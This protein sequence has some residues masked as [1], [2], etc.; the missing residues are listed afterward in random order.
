L[1]LLKGKPSTGDVILD[2]NNR[3]LVV[4]REQQALLEFVKRA[5]RGMYLHLPL[6]LVMGGCVELFAAD[7]WVFW[8]TEYHG[9]AHANSQ[10]LAVRSAPRGGSQLRG[11]GGVGAISL[12]H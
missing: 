10:P 7:P 12:L 4:R 1:E 2:S 11:H 6:W 9:C 5:K 3:E 8:I